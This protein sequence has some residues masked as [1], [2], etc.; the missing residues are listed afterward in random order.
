MTITVQ[1]TWPNASSPL[2]P[3]S[4]V[5]LSLRADGTKLTPTQ[6]APG[7]R[8]FDVPAGTSS[9]SL[10]ARFNLTL[11]SV[12]AV[13]LAIDQDFDVTGSTQIVARSMPDYQG[14]HPLVVA[15][16]LAGAHG[17]ASV[18]LRTDFVDASAFWAHYAD[19]W[20]YYL[21][22]HEPGTKVY[23]LGLTQGTP[24][25]WFAVVPDR[26]ISLTNPAVP[27][28]VF[29][30]PANQY[31]YT[32]LDQAHK[33]W[34]LIRY[35]LKPREDS[36]SAARDYER[37]HCY[38]GPA[39]DLMF[40]R[41]EDALVASRRGVV[42]LNPWPS[43]GDFGASSTA[44]L[45]TFC[46]QA[47]RFLAAQKAI[48]L[49]VPNVKL[50]RLGLS[51][52]SF[53]GFAMWAALG[54]NMSRVSEVYAFD[55]RDSGNA[56]AL[57]T[58]WFGA[59]PDPMLRLVGGAYRVR[60]YADLAKA[61]APQGSPR[62]SLALGTEDWFNNGQNIVWEHYIKDTPSLRDARAGQ[63][64]RHQFAICG[65]VIP[66]NGTYDLDFVTTYLQAFLMSSNFIRL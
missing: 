65:G 32:R 29:Y 59:C 31:S 61:L 22:R 45:P 63:D 30:R 66:G 16:S 10:N 20:S 21:S 53:G 54:N 38:G 39:G 23:V 1:I 25:L 37:D 43:Q 55:C 4:G 47:I 62:V 11:G 64:A 35:L 12:S 42:M 24:L 7:K 27:C 6:T 17:A 13:V 19:Y 41:F 8:R 58:Q 15:R 56:A 14:P 52:F 5:D 49:G 60:P 9:L 50:G 44:K 40:C 26:C 3:D 34:G 36:D 57:A 33:T 2:L 48:A 46:T 18:V 28:L 51:G